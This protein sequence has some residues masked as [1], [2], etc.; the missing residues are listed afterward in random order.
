MHVP[1]FFECVGS[2]KARVCLP[3]ECA[4]RMADASM[5][6]QDHD[7]CTLSAATSAVCSS[8]LEIEPAPSGSEGGL[9]DDLKI[10]SSPTPSSSRETRKRAR[11]SFSENYL[12][13]EKPNL[14][15]LS[16]F[17][18]LGTPE[19]PVTELMTKCC[20][21]RKAVTCFKLLSQAD[22]ERVRQEF[23]SC[24][25]ETQQTQ[26]LLHYMREHSR[27]D[28]SVLYTVA[29]QEVCETSFRMVYGLRYNR[30]SSVKARF[31]S[32]VV[33]AEHG[34][35]GKSHIGDASIR[36]T[37]WLRTF[38]QKVGDRMP[39]STDIHLPSCLTKADVY[40]LAV[41]DLSQGGLSCCKPSTFYSI[42]KSEFPHVKIPK[43]IIEC[44]TIYLATT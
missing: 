1:S 20:C 41:D 24:S 18:Y 36:V 15:I 34:R 16:I 31:A 28:K 32:G 43:V 30:F 9:N 35:L 17:M 3:C 2:A 14:F 8:G 11:G 5:E 19:F 7:G 33:V 27:G 10:T 40:A 12:L 6:D 23:Y 42:W 25:T 22:I 38:V 37:C 29:G 4:L 44:P 13:H 39:T 21:D 26:Y